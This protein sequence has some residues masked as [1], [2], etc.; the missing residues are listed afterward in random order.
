MSDTA[1]DVRDATN[2]ATLDDKE[3]FFF[4]FDPRDG[5]AAVK[6]RGCDQTE[7]PLLWGW[8][9]RW[10]LS[11]PTL[12]R[13]RPDPPLHPDRT[14]SSHSVPPA[15]LTDLFAPTDCAPS[16]SP[17]I[18]DGVASLRFFLATEL[19]AFL[20]CFR[21]DTEGVRC[22]GDRWRS[23]VEDGYVL[24]PVFFGPRP[25]RRE[26]VAEADVEAASVCLWEV[27][28]GEDLQLLDAD[29]LELGWLVPAAGTM[30]PSIAS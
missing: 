3:G 18:G 26:P 11:R 21:L 19:V 12:V 24:R 25:L 2:D 6:V 23:S 14:E 8:R 4:V 9:W 10:D 1:N 13:W 28:A 20:T 7:S 22:V 17:E 29:F 15:F 27:T 30:M 5:E 16:L